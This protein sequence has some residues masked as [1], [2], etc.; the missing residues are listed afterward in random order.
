MENKISIPELKNQIRFLESKRSQDLRALKDQL[1]FT[2]ESLRP[3]NLIRD[4]LHEVSE[5]PDLK[6]NFVNSSIGMAT[7]FVTNRLF[8]QGSHNP[9]KRAIGSLLQIGIT[10]IVTKNPGP[11]KT[12]GQNIFNRIFKKE[13]QENGQGVNGG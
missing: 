3:V 5:A 1:H 11:I 12:I 10:N 4:T 6:E 9:I 2:F 8:M 13:P 7:G